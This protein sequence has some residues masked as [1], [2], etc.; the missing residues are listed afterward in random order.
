MKYVVQSVKDLGVIINHFQKHPLLTKKYADFVLFEQI[1]YMVKNLDHLSVEGLD[2][3]VAIKASLN[4]GL[5]GN[6]ALAFPT[7]VAVAKPLMECANI[8][9]G[10]PYWLA[11]FAS[12]E[13]C[14]NVTIFKSK[15]VIGYAVRFIFQVTQHSRDEAL[16]IKLAEY[17]GCGRLYKD[18][19]T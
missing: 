11:G 17:I 8:K 16:L 10:S 15:T 5:S 14:F 13:G 4:K 3:M 19:D 9:F 12:A 7:V 1:Y 2:K 6:L 18:R